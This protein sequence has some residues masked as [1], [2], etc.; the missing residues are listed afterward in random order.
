MKNDN[1]YEVCVVCGEQTDVLKSIHIDMR[2]GYIEGAGQLCHFCAPIAH[3]VVLDNK[4]YIDMNAI[5]DIPNDTELGVYV[6]NLY[7]KNKK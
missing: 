4:L 3:P 5:S 7:W 6:R 2:T 1:D